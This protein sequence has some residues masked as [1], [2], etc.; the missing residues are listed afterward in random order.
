MELTYE[1]TAADFLE[2]TEAD[3]LRLCEASDI[4]PQAGHVKRLSRSIVAKIGFDVSERE[5]LD[6]RYAFNN[7]NVSDRRLLFQR[8]AQRVRAS[9][10]SVV[11]SVPKHLRRPPG[12]CYIRPSNLLD[13]NLPN[14]PIH[15]TS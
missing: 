9:Y 14:L 7:D 2:A 4:L 6:S 13:P 10:V 11:P 12:G 1:S 8:C 15:P 5:Y 3:I